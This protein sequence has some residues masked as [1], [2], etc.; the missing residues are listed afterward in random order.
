MPFRTIQVKCSREVMTALRLKA[1]RASWASCSGVVAALFIFLN[2]AERCRGCKRNFASNLHV[3][4][5][6]EAATKPGRAERFRAA[7]DPG[8]LREQQ[9]RIWVPHAAKELR[10]SRPARHLD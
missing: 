3:A 9:A 2:L 5:A 6:G 7:A 4:L 1:S 8:L 10:G